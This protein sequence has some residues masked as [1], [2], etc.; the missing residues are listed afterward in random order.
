MPEVFRIVNKRG[1]MHVYSYLKG[2]GRSK[3]TLY[4]ILLDLVQCI[5]EKR[6]YKS[7]FI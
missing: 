3:V 5:E 7:D 2:Q 4:G 6:F 1:K